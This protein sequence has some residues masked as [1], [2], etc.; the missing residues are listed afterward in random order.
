MRATD[1]KGKHA[2]RAER[3]P[4]RLLLLLLLLLL[5]GSQMMQT[6]LSESALVSRESPLDMPRRQVT[7]SRPDRRLGSREWCEG[8][9][10]GRYQEQSQSTRHSTLA[11]QLVL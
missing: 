2:G 7:A 4:R 9:A 5:I 8:C 1:A 6:L 11:G 3:A 10:V